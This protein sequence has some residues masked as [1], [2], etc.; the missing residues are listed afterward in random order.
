MINRILYLF[1]FPAFFAAQYGC[2]TENTGKRL[3]DLKESY[4]ITDKK[5][6]GAYIAYH[7]LQEMFYRNTLR[8]EKRNFEEVGYS[9][10]DTASLYISLTRTLYST[11]D[12]ASGFIRFIEK[13]ND[14]FIVS[15]E[16]EDNLLNKLECNVTPVNYLE[17]YSDKPFHHTTVGIKS[18]LPVDSGSYGFFYLPFSASFST[19]NRKNTR[20]L[21]VNGSGEPDFI[22]IFKG[23]GRIFLHCEPRAF[24]NYFLLQQN[25]YQY[26]EKAFGFPDAYPEHVYWNNYYVKLRSK[27]Q[28]RR[29][30]NEDDNNSFSS[31]S[32]LLSYP[33]LA[34]AFWLT[35][36]LLLLYILLGVKRRQRVIEVIKPNENTT[37]AF[38]ETIGR[39]YLQKKD[40]KN[41]A[42]KMITYFNEYI[43][44][45][46]FLNTH[47]IN[48]DFITTLSRKSGVAREKVDSLYRAIAYSQ[49]HQVIDDF[50]LMSLNEQVQDFFRK[51]Q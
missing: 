15:R 7:L 8:D 48:D 12:D 1:Y 43:R 35:L 25:N 17:E 42:D 31:F 19:Y 24:S 21:G 37:V 45:N 23:K 4:L 20:V 3:P 5:P 27:D 29:R 28:A 49:N 44:N 34:K 18:G 33:P 36:S 11:D 9:L 10:D 46:Y 50:Q 32:T 16:F 51:I 13:G 30:H 22:V 47:L 2:S 39:L 6:F 26:L 40:N 14:A 38:T 41:I